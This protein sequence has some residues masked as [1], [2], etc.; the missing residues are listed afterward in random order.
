MEV[1]RSRVQDSQLIGRI[2]TELGVGNI[3]SLC[4][5]CT[6][7]ACLCAFLMLVVEDQLLLLALLAL[8]VC[9]V[10]FPCCVCIPNKA[11]SENE[12]RLA[13]RISFCKACT[14]FAFL[15]A[16][17]MQ[18]HVERETV[19]LFLFACSPR[20]DSFPPFLFERS[21]AL[22]SFYSTTAKRLSGE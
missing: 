5:A 9:C 10:C 19:L 15:C 8:L 20:S 1:S 22:L 11:A 18:S 17:T 14:L 2:L 12:P 16:F 7:C 21:L 6:L 4:K 3:I 13:T